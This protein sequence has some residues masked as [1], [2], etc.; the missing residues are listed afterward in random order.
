M[1]VF[2]VGKQEGICEFFLSHMGKGGVFTAC[3]VLEHK[4]WGIS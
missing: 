1:S 4:G 3:F 2:V